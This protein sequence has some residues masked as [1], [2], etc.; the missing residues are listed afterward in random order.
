VG[1]LGVPVAYGLRSGHVSRRNITLPL[2]VRAA[3]NV[4][5][6]GV[7]VRIMEAATKK[8]VSSRPAG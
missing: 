4:T 2:G 8:A 7:S 6:S 1:D 5:P 3:L